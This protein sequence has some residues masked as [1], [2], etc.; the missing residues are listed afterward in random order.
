M[1]YVSAVYFA[2]AD[3][4]CLDRSDPCL[5]FKL[6]KLAKDVDDKEWL[7][8]AFTVSI[9]LLAFGGLGYSLFPYLVLDQISIWD[10]ASATKSLQFVL[11]GVLVTVPAILGYTIFAYRIFWGKT[12]ALSYD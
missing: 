4:S 8:F 11:W 12:R 2:V 5:Y 9:F 6:S 10:A 3:T 1:V 7:P